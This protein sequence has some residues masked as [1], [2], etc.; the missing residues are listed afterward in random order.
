MFECL[1]YI[2]CVMDIYWPLPFVFHWKTRN[3]MSRDLN[4]INGSNSYIIPITPSFSVLFNVYMA[5]SIF[6]NKKANLFHKCSYLQ[7]PLAISLKCLC[8]GRTTKQML[9]RHRG[10]APWWWLLKPF[11]FL[12]FCALCWMYW[13]LESELSI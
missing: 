12:L 4:L 8:T 5:K 7:K 10:C 9:S 13:K 3:W 2:I 6:W 1:I 11:S